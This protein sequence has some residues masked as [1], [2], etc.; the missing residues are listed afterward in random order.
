MLISV[1]LRSSQAEGRVEICCSRRGCAGV[2]V[3]TS[4][5]VLYS[6]VVCRFLQSFLPQII[7]AAGS[8]SRPARNEG[9]CSCLLAAGL[10]MLSC[11]FLPC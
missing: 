6:E 4:L 3:A 11:S 5:A 10:P 2:V 7:L 8:P 9:F 1:C